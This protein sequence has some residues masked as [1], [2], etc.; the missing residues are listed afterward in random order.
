MNQVMVNMH[1]KK[2]N[3][4]SCIVRGEDKN[5]LPTIA[6]EF[7]ATDMMGLSWILLEGDP[8]TC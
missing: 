5:P 4:P 3:M 7:D 1:V 8:L 2:T 6:N